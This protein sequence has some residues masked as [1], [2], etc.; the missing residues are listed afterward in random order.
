MERDL[1][2]RHRQRLEADAAQPRGEQVLELLGRPDHGEPGK[3]AA[4]LLRWPWRHRT[5]ST[6]L[7]SLNSSGVVSSVVV[8]TPLLCTR[9]GTGTALPSILARPISSCRIVSI[10]GRK[11]VAGSG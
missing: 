5:A 4:H 8:R 7:A 1:A 11:A 10:S 9:S 3:P 2:R 6:K